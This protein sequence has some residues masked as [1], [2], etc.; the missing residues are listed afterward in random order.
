MSA[1]LQIAGKGLSNWIVQGTRTVAGP[2]TSHGNAIAALPG[3]AARLRTVT[4]RACLGCTNH[5]KSTGPGHR[6]CPSCKRDA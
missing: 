5:F 3:V 6:L 4:I 1:D 2:F